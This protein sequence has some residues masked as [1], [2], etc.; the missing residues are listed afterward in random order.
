[1]TS[2]S[3]TRLPCIGLSSYR[4]GF[5]QTRRLLRFRNWILRPAVSGSEVIIAVRDFMA[6][7]SPLGA[8]VQPTVGEFFRIGE[9]I[10]LWS[11]TGTTANTGISGRRCQ[12]SVI[13]IFNL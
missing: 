3:G 7:Q 9:L 6:A 13:D 10:D 5:G 1:M 12:G 2:H 4:L 8:N 11:I